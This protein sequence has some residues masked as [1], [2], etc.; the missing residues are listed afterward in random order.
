MKTHDRFSFLLPAFFLLTLRIPA[1]AADL[2]EISCAPFASGFDAPTVMIPF[3]TGDRAFLVAEQTGVIHFLDESG[4]Q[5][6]GVFLD[7]SESLVTLRE[8][9]DE[10]GLLGLA[11]HPDFPN[12][13]KCY[14]YYSAPLRNGAPEGFDHTGRLVEFRIR[15]AGGTADPDSERILLSIDEPQFNHDGGNLLFGADRCLYIGVGDGGGANDQGPGHAEGGNGQALDR[16]LG[17]ILRIDVDSGDPYGI[18]ADNPLSENQGRKEI[19]AWGLRNPWGLTLDAEG[20]NR[21]IAADV[22]QNRFEEV[23]L[24]RKG[25]NYGW[26]RLEGRARFDPDQPNQPPAEAP[27]AGL[28]DER[29]F[30]PPLIV[31]P[32][33][34]PYGESP[35]FGISVTG[36]H[37]YRGSAIPGL[38]GVYVFADWASSWG[39]RPTRLFAAVEGSAGQ[40]QVAALPGSQSPVDR[41]LFVVGF[42]RDRDG[43][44]YVLSTGEKAPGGDQG[45][46]W[47]IVPAGE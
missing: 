12:Q 1:G 47:K 41:P 44:L 19:F 24:I 36:G 13:R 10:R 11:L 39:A 29:A 40:W 42:A 9:F 5:P 28:E 33:A 18:P 8:G 46:I 4:G 38:R 43:E 37:V 32:H 3:E 27:A 6:G 45:E 22:G 25:A 30:E 34:T 2:P 31:Y 16:L 7:L 26:P 35:V 23:N 20:G 15:A 14:V 17:K 21:I